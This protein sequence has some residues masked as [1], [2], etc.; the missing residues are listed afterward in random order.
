[1]RWPIVR[2]S[3]PLCVVRPGRALSAHSCPPGKRDSSLRHSSPPTRCAESA[4][5]SSRPAAPCRTSS[6][7]PWVSGVAVPVVPEQGAMGGPVAA[8]SGRSP[9]SSDLEY[10]A[11][12]AVGCSLFEPHPPHRGDLRAQ[13]LRPFPGRHMPCN[14]TAFNPCS[15]A[16]VLQS[17]PSH[18]INAIPV[19]LRLA[20][21]LN[22]TSPRV[23]FHPAKKK[24]SLALRCFFF[25]SP[26]LPSHC[27]E[28][29]PNPYCDPEH[30]LR[31]Q[32]TNFHASRAKSFWTSAP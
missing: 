3:L 28:Q 27:C 1:M 20:P 4:S 6:A 21:T 30:M 16:E 11:P 10:P 29:V 15:R 7:T 26:C 12:T 9:L 18:A 2:D 23:F 17:S 8:P 14:L 25:S 5:L 13:R 19:G 32:M 22:C 24:S 31:S